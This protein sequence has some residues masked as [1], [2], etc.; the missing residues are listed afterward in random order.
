MERITDNLSVSAGKLFGQLLLSSYNY[1][2]AVSKSKV[3]SIDSIDDIVSIVYFKNH[4]KLR[5]QN[6]IKNY[7][8]CNMANL[9][10]GRNVCIHYNQGLRN[11]RNTQKTRSL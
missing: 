10:P 8:T 7:A 2:G 9:I 4:K 5:I 3:F 1:K 6:E 11:M